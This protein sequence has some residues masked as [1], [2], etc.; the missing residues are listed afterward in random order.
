MNYKDFTKSIFR[1]I[2]QV[3]LQ[4]NAITGFIFLIAVVYSSWL[5]GIG[6]LIGTA[7]GTLTAIMLKYKEKDVL[8]G[9]YGFN[10]TLVGI[11]LLFF[12]KPT[13]FLFI[14]LIIAAA[15]S[16]IVMNFMHKKKFMPY[17]FPFVLTAWVFIFLIKSFNI[18]PSSIPETVYFTQADILSAIIL[19]FSQV[20]L[21]A[22]VITGILFFIGILIN[23]RISAVYALAGSTIGLLTGL[24]FFPSLINLINIGIFGFNGVLCGIAFSDKKRHSFIFA[25]TAIILSAGIIYG[26]IA[27]NF[28]ALTAPFVFAAWITVFAKNKIHKI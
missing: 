13:G 10:G 9:L 28:I 16:A 17:T 21:Q 15:I 23:S 1:G 2:G 19:G 5:M 3:M 25:V 12:F 11:S 4:N 18:V 14:I 20:M 6:A 26:F 24:L 27:L 22:S 8:G 7:T